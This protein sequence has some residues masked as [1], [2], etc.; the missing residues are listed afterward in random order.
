MVFSAH[1]RTIKAAITAWSTAALSAVLLLT[2]CSAQTVTGDG[3]PGQPRPGAPD[4]EP[5]TAET[6]P[7][8]ETVP[9]PQA[10]TAADPS[11][12]AGPRAET[13]GILRPLQIR[14]LLADPAEVFATDFETDYQ[15]AVAVVELL[16]LPRRVHESN[17]D[18]ESQSAA[19]LTLLGTFTHDSLETTKESYVSLHAA[20]VRGTAEVTLGIISYR[21]LSQLQPLWE[22]TALTCDD[23]HL[24]DEEGTLHRV[25]H[26]AYDDVDVLQITPE[27]K[28]PASTY[29]TSLDHGHNTLTVSASGI[30]EQTFA[31]LVDRQKEHLGLP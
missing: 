6:V 12:V 20:E 14:S 2:G 8:E 30:D 23:A 10:D 16:D 4:A 26:I 13:Y 21:R 17:D 22:Q 1:R 27:G 3:H 11:P 19:C 24:A 9:V 31:E 15:E 5:L 25:E 18:G 7:L 28:G 29:L